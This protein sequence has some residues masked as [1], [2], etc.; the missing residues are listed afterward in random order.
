MFPF[1]QQ[2]LRIFQVLFQI[3]K[4]GGVKTLDFKTLAC[5]FDCFLSSLFGLRQ[6]L[7]KL[8][9]VLGID[10]K[11]VFDK[12]VFESITVFIDILVKVQ[13]QFV[14]DWHPC[15]EDIE[16]LLCIFENTFIP[17]NSFHPLD[18]IR[19]VVYIKFQLLS[20]QIPSDS[21]E[22]VSDGRKHLDVP[23]VALETGFN[24]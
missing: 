16:Y 17:I 2:D 13:S 24:L 14:D 1:F 8:Y 4:V 6:S 18:K 12:L 21:F 10:V 22:G 15:L 19:G 20:N 11:N 23:Q 5:F 9:H 3:D 7:E